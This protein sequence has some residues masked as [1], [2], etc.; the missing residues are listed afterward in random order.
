MRL[1]NGP[2]HFRPAELIANPFQVGPALLLSMQPMT[3]RAGGPRIIV[4]YPLTIFAMPLLRQC[5][6]PIL[7]RIEVRRK[8]R[9]DNQES[10]KDESSHTN[11]LIR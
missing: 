4:E 9:A 7:L 3:S 6:L 5:E 10:S 1:K 8:R 11:F 2:D